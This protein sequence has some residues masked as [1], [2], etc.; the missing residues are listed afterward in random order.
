V[1]GADAAAPPRPPAGPPDRIP[2]RLRAEGGDQSL[3]Y[4]L[5]VEDLTAGQAGV[6]ENGRR[7]TFG[8]LLG[9][10]V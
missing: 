1:C 5:H 6:T 4:R 2:D 9:G 10:T 8:A 7:H 3:T